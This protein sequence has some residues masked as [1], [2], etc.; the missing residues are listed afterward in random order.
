MFQLDTSY[1]ESRREA[2]GVIVT[3]IFIVSNIIIT[4]IVE[5]HISR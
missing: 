4:N 5:P 1:G 3:T 2:Y